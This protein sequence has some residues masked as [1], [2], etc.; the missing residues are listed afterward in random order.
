MLIIILKKNSK[1]KLNRLY[2]ANTFIDNKLLE[3][4]NY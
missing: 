4:Y 3:F 1:K 2:L